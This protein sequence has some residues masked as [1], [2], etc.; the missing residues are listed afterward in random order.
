MTYEEFK[1]TYKWTTK[2]YPGTNTFCGLMEKECGTVEKIEYERVGDRWKMVN[3]TEEPF[4]GKFSMNS[5]EAV[6]FFRR[7]GGTERVTKSYT[8]YG[9]VPVTI[10]STSPDGF[11]KVARNYH[12]KG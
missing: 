11:T 7:L 12:F 3:K 10:I 6:P 4:T 2:N 1:S 9:Y 8:P 5:V